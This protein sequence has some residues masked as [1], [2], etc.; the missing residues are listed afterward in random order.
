MWKTYLVRC[1][2]PSLCD[3]SLAILNTHCVTHKA[4]DTIRLVA[5]YRADDLELGCATPPARPA[6]PDKPTLVHPSMVPQRKG[7]IGRA[8]LLHALAHIE[9][10]ALDL[11][12]DTILL[13]ANHGMEASFFDDWLLVAEQEAHHFLGLH[14]RLVSFGFGYGDFDAHDGLWEAAEVTRDCLRAR[15]VIV[16]LVL[17]ARG[18]D[19]TPSIMAKLRKAG[20][21]GSAAQLQVI[22]AE[23]VGHVALGAKWF[24]RLCKIDG[25]DP[26][27]EFREIIQERF[28][29]K[30]K[31][32]FNH[33]ARERA[34][35]P[36]RFYDHELLLSSS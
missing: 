29:G 10:N 30:L 22:Y 19:V 13:A 21:A 1:D 36:A 3:A 14:K 20:D 9:L 35:F 12:L 34:G 33:E 23:E 15:M 7:K 8:Q 16:P 2:Q 6:R 24:G 28:R 5:R 18:L 17:E 31:L 27:E 32:P 4:L 25:C 26:E 11:A